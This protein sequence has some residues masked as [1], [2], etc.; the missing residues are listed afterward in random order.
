MG[1]M[2][3]AFQE[4]AIRHTAISRIRVTSAVERGRTVAVDGVVDGFV[5]QHKRLIYMAAFW[6]MVRVAV[7]ITKV[8]VVEV[9]SIS[10]SILSM[11]VGPFKQWVETAGIIVV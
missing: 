5:S 4:T 7:A 10:M 2:E 3:I 6:R 1:G 11:E 8:A 9:E